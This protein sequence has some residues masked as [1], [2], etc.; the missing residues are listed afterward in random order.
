MEENN[1]VI[2]KKQYGNI[3]RPRVKEL[4]INLNGVKIYEKDLYFSYTYD[5]FF[6]KS[7]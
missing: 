2:F 3:K 6:N 7:C 4:A 1:Y 5:V